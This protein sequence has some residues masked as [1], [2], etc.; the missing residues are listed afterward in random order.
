MKQSFILT[1]LVVLLIQLVNI[2]S[3]PVISNKLKETPKNEKKTNLKKMRFMQ[4]NNVSVDIKSS[5][6]NNTIAA[7]SAVSS[8]DSHDHI[9]ANHTSTNNA[10]GAENHEA[11]SDSLRPDL[12]EEMPHELE[13]ELELLRQ[14]EGVVNGDQKNDSSEDGINNV[15]QIITNDPILGNGK[16]KNE[17]DET[18]KEEF[19][20]LDFF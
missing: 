3:T 14:H 9:Q 5:A 18:Y 20:P 1:I 11:D 17:N 13:E 10:N 7:P 16:V 6:S 2:L 15:D 8:K 19:S 12:P 4:N